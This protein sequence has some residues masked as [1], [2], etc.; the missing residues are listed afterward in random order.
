M[1]KHVS[2]YSVDF[3]NKIHRSSQIEQTPENRFKLAISRRK[4]DMKLNDSIISDVIFRQMSWYKKKAEKEF[5]LFC[6]RTRSFLQS[7]IKKQ[8]I[9]DTF[10]S[11]Y[12]SFS[13][14][15]NPLNIPVTVRLN[16]RRAPKVSHS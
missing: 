9:K 8:H 1:S 12:L 10:P 6:L 11:S 5:T 16:C 3:S 15:S 4:I 13:L 2:S 7:T 14:N